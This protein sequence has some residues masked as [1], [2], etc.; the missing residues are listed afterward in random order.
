[1][2]LHQ[3]RRGRCGGGRF[4]RANRATPRGAGSAAATRRQSP[5]LHCSRAKAEALTRKAVELALVGE[6]TA[7]RLCLERILPPVAIAWSSLPCRRSRV[8]PRDKARG[9]KGHDIAAA[10]KMVTSAL[11]GGVI[12]RGEAATIAAELAVPDLDLIKQ[13]EQGVRDRRERFATGRSGNP[14]GRPRDW[15][16]IPLSRR[17][18]PAISGGVC[19]RS[20]PTTPTPRTPQ[21][22]RKAPARIGPTTH[23]RYFAVDS[24]QMAG[25][26]TIDSIHGCGAPRRPGRWD[27]T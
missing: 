14:A 16:S 4:K 11:A 6:P 13:D 1:M 19:S 24:L 20:R 12:T 2:G 10:M 5:L 21:P 18:R 8:L 9:P 17:S 22:V 25:R 27:S 23:R 26:A 7:M 15:W 3:N